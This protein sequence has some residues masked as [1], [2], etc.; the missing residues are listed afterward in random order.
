MKNDKNSSVNYKR[1]LQ[2]MIK[3]LFELRKGPTPWGKAFCAGLCAGLPVLIGILMG[4]FELGLLGGIGG[5]TYL[6]VFNETYVSRMK[7]IFLVAVTISFLVGLGTIVA[8]YHWLVIL[9]IGLIGF[10]AT[11]IFGVLK[12]PGP[13]AI[14]FILSFTITTSMP[15]N[16]S[17]AP[18][19]F[20]VVL[21]SGLFAWA[22]SMVGWVKNPHK[23]EI[24]A[25]E[26]VYL[27]L[28]GFCGAIGSEDMNNK[29]QMVI[30]ALRRGEETLSSG[31]VSKKNKMEFNRLVL[32]N[33][34]A[35]DLFIEL[36]EVSF[37]SSSKVP[38]EITDRIRELYKNIR[39]KDG[40]VDKID[41]KRLSK[42]SAGEYTKLLDSIYDIEKLMNMHLDGI[43]SEVS[44][45]VRP[46][47]RMKLIKALDM[48]FIVFVNS[49]R[50]GVVLSIS[51]IVAFCFPFTRPYW[52]PLSCAA[53]MF[54][55]T[56]MSTFNRAV[57]RCFGTIVGVLIAT[58]I[59]SLHPAGIIVAIIN[60]ILTM[61]TELVVVRNYALVAMF[62]TPNALILAEAAT[63]NSN[64][65]QFI[66]GRV[67]DI[68]VGS[69]IGLIGTYI[70]GRKS[71]SSRLP[72]LITK[73][74][75][76]Q[77]RAIVRLEA[78]KK[79]NNI[80]DIQWIKEK[81]E[82]NLG[83]LK[84]AYNTALGEIPRNQ[85]KLEFM[86][87]AIASL[88]H[89]SY[90]IGKNIEGREYIRL[91]DQELAQILMVLEKIAT[92]VEQKHVLKDIRTLDIDDIPKICK[93]VN[94]LQEILSMK[95]MFI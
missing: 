57:L 39:L 64:P 74:I 15:I 95:N 40:E 37:Y 20:L 45:A 2:F 82:I 53:V 26:D 19:R 24:K 10:M 42:E 38:Q 51:A 89:I 81:M 43:E 18:L 60:M 56:I 27:S 25:V 84:L 73:L 90:L 63:K 76:S 22:L 49:V 35:D 66:T 69:M 62:I 93:E 79:N 86:W 83:N 55:T 88:E 70:I 23:S 16:P 34:Y 50:Y 91:S 41:L 4:N 77:S 61:I 59:L 32:L 14:F 48:D 54:G 47:R 46:S 58:C 68:I 75:R 94:N 17:Q 80:Q 36:I 52:I 28:G 12:V 44:K 30:E 92:A 11:F 3:Q 87:P 7:K 65:S 33:Q 21:A 85:E 5:F 71:A 29:R 6:Y 31:Y 1:N 78:N 67:T 8:P 72:G 13:A 9:I